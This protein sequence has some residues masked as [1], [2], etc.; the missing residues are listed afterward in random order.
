MRTIAWA[1]LA[2]MAEGRSPRLKRVLV[3]FGLRIGL[4]A[5]RPGKETPPLDIHL[6]GEPSDEF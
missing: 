1:K 2:A 4:G 5:R 6:R 3:A